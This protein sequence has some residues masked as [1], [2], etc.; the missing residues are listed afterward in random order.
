MRISPSM[1]NCFHSSKTEFMNRYVNR[2]A[3]EQTIYMAIGSAFDDIVKRTLGYTGV[4]PQVDHPSAW[5][6]AKRIF[7]VYEKVGLPT[8]IGEIGTSLKIMEEKVVRDVTLTTSAGVSFDVTISCKPDLVTS[9]GIYDW[10]VNGALTKG[11]QKKGHTLS[12]NVVTSL[13]A[14]GRRVSSPSPFIS[15]EYCVQLFMGA[16]ATGCSLYG[17]IDQMAGEGAERLYSYRGEVGDATD[18]IYPVWLYWQEQEQD[19]S[20]NITRVV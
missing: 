7:K 15:G 12:R 20:S 13:D 18:L 8:L 5:D 1:V 17:G 6:H 16:I 19:K 10:K 11:S 14:S 2:V 4:A 3:M 9:Y